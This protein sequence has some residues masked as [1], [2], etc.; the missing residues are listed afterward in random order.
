MIY[1]FKS[2]TFLKSQM[3]KVINDI[4]L[5]ITTNTMHLLQTFYYDQ[6]DCS[7]LIPKDTI[8]FIYISYTF[9]KENYLRL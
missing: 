4:S 8:C 2:F 7:T 6:I 3:I 5:F 9:S 1:S